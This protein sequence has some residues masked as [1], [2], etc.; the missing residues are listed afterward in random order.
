VV[1]AVE[2]LL[3][4]CEALSSKPSPIKKEKEKKSGALLDFYNLI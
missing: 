3:C 4:K 2:Y 1:Q